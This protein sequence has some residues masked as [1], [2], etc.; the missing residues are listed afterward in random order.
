MVKNGLKID[1]AVLNADLRYVK[2]SQVAIEDAFVNGM[3]EIRDELKDIK[4]LQGANR[5]EIL[6]AKSGI[7]VL[8][9]AGI[10]VISLITVGMT[11]Y[12]ALR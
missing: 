9:A 7:K 4:Q 8:R 6:V 2:E 12:A 11:V 1:V 10:A 5:D 3:K